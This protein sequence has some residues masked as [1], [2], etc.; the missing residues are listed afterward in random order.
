MVMPTLPAAE[1]RSEPVYV[2]LRPVEKIQ[3]EAAAAKVGLS[4]GSYFRQLFLI[5]QRR[6]RSVLPAK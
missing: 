3:L 4:R 5:D 2:L 1:K 6:R